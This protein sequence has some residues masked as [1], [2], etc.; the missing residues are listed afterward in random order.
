MHPQPIRREIRRNPHSGDLTVY[1]IGLDKLNTSLHDSQIGLE[2]K[3]FDVFPTLPKDG[4]QVSIITPPIPLLILQAKPVGE[5]DTAVYDRESSFGADERLKVNRFS[6]SGLEVLVETFISRVEQLRSDSRYQGNLRQ[7]YPY[8]MFNPET[9]GEKLI[10]RHLSSKV[11]APAIEDEIRIA[12]NFDG[13]HGRCMY[14][15]IIQE[16]NKKSG[17][18]ES[19]VV[20]ITKQYIGIQP[21]ASRYPYEIHIFPRRHIARIIELN[22]YEIADLALIF[23]DKLYKIVSKIGPVNIAFHS[24]P[25]YNRGDPINGKV[26]L[27]GIYHTHIEITQSSLSKVYEIPS[28]RIFV[29]DTRPKDAAKELREML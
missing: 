15:D 7:F 13:Q 1:L 3:E 20:F 10:G 5:L 14:C 23:S 21:F 18:D 9:E 11:I 22:P 19:R 2:G 16:E 26:I 4:A 8:I 17:A 25:Y 27:E 6:N 12:K 28:S 24:L 29:M